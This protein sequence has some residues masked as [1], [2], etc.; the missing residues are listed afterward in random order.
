MLD[1]KIKNDLL[2]LKNKIAD[3]LITMPQFDETLDN[4]EKYGGSFVVQL[5]KLFRV[6]D[7]NNKRKLF[8]AFIEY[9]EEYQPANWEKKGKK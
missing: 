7:P 2:D 3:L 1:K 6:A 9:L 5:S 8:E 4:M